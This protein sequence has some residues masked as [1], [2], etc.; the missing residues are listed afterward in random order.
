[1]A[2]VPRTGPGRRRAGPWLARAV[3]LAALTAATALSAPSLRA[4]EAAP[5]RIDV[6]FDSGPSAVPGSPGEGADAGVVAEAES[7]AGSGAKAPAAVRK[8]T[9]C[10]AQL[11]AGLVP[12]GGFVRDPKGRY[13]TIQPAGACVT[14]AYGVDNHGQ[15]VGSYRAGGYMIGEGTVRGFI[16]RRGRL[17]TFGLPGLDRPG[18]E[19]TVTDIDDRGRLLGSTLEVATGAGHGFLRDTDGRI[20]LIDHPGA[21]GTALGGSGTIAAQLTNR[22]EIV[23]YYAAGGTV[24]GFVRDRRGRFATIDRPGAKAT[25]VTGINERG[26]LV[27]AS[28]AA[29]PAELFTSPEAFLLTKGVYTGVKVPGALATSANVINNRGQI[30]GAYLDGGGRIHG[31]RRDRAGRFITID[32]PD[33]AMSTV[34]Q[35]LNDLGQLS[36]LYDRPVTG[37]RRAS[38]QWVFGAAGLWSSMV[39]DLELSPSPAASPRAAGRVAA[40][41]PSRRAAS[42][43]PS[44]SAGSSAAAGDPGTRTGADTR[45]H[46]PVPG[47]LLDHGR[48]TRFDAP[49]ARGE[50]TPLGINNLGQV[51]GSYTDTDADATY[52]GFLRD[53]RGRITTIDIPGARATVASRINDR[54]QIVGRYYQT[55]PFRGPDARPRGFLLD[56]GRLTRIDVPG[57]A[58]TQAVGIDNRGRVVGEYQDDAGAFHG[59]LRDE[60]GGFTT[61]DLPGA[62][63]TSLVAINNAGQVLGGSLDPAGGFHNFLLDRGCFTTFDAPGV[64]FTFA[65]D[66]ND[67]GQ[68]VGFTLTDL[69]T[70]AGARGF[71]LARGVTGPF[72]TVDVPGASRDAVSGLNDRGQLVGYYEVRTR[73][74]SARPSAF[75]PGVVNVAD[76]EAGRLEPE[77]GSIHAARVPAAIAEVFTEMVRCVGR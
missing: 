3:L 44:R 32:H 8:P 22:G 13:A 20:T 28:S 30:A 26:Q 76:M 67:R 5:V 19:A 71:L 62:A 16:Y 35:G 1:L 72:T 46:T 17:V 63:G 68:I 43:R 7:G 24:H 38:R 2:S 48:Y 37:A 31:F 55:A 33:S 45:P 6:S 27:G 18:V 49:G 21:A 59:F 4:R 40:K 36:G 25:A 12:A 50:T 54:G 9:A 10:R 61:I 65:R 29:G 14:K 51:V 53:P 77:A 57:A 42:P 56:R 15:V 69:A 60:H 64:P 47:F 73:S 39:P 23:G 70:L 34:V 52:H 74:Q 41:R 11:P 58:S 66:L 75:L